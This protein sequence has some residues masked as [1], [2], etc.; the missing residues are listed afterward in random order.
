MLKNCFMQLLVNL[1][2]QKGK[3]NTKSNNGNTQN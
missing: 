3:N 2:M 1:A